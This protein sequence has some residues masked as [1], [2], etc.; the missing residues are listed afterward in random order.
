MGFSGKKAADA[1]A[2]A[3]EHDHR[4][5]TETIA[6]QAEQAYY[7]LALAKAHERVMLAAVAAAEGHVRQARAMVAAGRNAEFLLRVKDLDDATQA[8]VRDQQRRAEEALRP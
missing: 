4:R 1:A 7:G 3:A 5:A 2:H 8:L 6:F